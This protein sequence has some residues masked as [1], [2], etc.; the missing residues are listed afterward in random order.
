MR[1]IVALAATVLLESWSFPVCADAAADKTVL[2]DEPAEETLVEGDLQS[3]DWMMALADFPIDESSLYETVVTGTPPHEEGLARVRIEREE[4]QQR[5]STTAA[6]VLEHQ[7]AVYGQTTPKGER[8]LRLRGFDQRGVTVYLDGVPLVMPWDS[9]MDLGKLPAEMIDSVLLLKGPTSI[10]HGPGGM[11]GAVLIETRDPGEG[12]LFEAE[13]ELGGLERVDTPDLRLNLYHGNEIGPVGYAVGFGHVGRQDYRLSS[14]YEPRQTVEGA[15]LRNENG[16]LDNSDRSVQHGATKLV[17]SLPEDNRLSAQLL[18]VNGEFGVPRSETDDRPFFYRYTVWRGIVTQLA[19]R[20]QSGNLKLEEAVYAGFYDNRLDGY[21]DDTY[22]T[23]EDRNAS[24][25]WYHDRIFGGRIRGQYTFRGL[26]AGDLY[27][28]LWLSAE[29]DMHQNQYQ[30]GGQDDDLHVFARTMIQVVP[31]VEVPIVSKLVATVSLQTD[32]EIPD[33][34]PAEL[35]RLTGA[36]ETLDPEVAFQPM[37]SL[38]Y[39]PLKVLMLRLTGAGRTRF[40][41]LSERFS[42]KIGYTRANPDLRKETAWYV[43]LEID[44]RAH[45]TVNVALAGF[46]AEVTDLI[47]AVYLPE[48]NGIQQ[49][50]N[51]GRARMAGAEAAVTYQ[52]IPELSLSAAYAYLYARRLDDVDEDRIAQIP[53]HQA[54]FGLV[55]D[56]AK[57]VSMATFFRIV[58]PQAF[59][60][61]TILGLGELGSYYVWDAHVAFTPID[62]FTVFIKGTNLLDMNYQTKY[63]YPDRGATLWLGVRITVNSIQR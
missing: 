59:D 36:A 40:P 9:S 37:V 55:S 22:S 41:S 38:R 48:T 45:R 50:Q 46:D 16:T 13:M 63:G 19:H 43:G 30:F 31:E 20:Y 61:Y 62:F 29:H 51:V 23:Q 35:E 58:G 4:I 28:R 57:W 47:H 5:G 25:S 33:V 17:I 12:P 52:P 18:L 54:T 3:E 42:S 53:A 8:M 7:P 39:D 11:G 60:D 6:E 1:L 24:S 34:D 49:K 27:A 21:D 10:V 56:P 14:Q 26:A 15:P 2:S 32:L 44:W